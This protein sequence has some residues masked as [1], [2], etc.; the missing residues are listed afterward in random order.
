MRTSLKSLFSLVTRLYDKLLSVIV[1]LGASLIV[2]MMLSIGA[3][4][5]FRRTI[6]DFAWALEISEYILI[7]STLFG[8]GWLLKTGGHVR[9]DALANLL[10]GRTRRVYN[11]IIFSL[12]SLVC[13]SFIL[14]GGHASYE[15]YRSG[16]IEEKVYLQFPKWILLS[17]FP[18]GGVFMTIEAIKL[19]VGSFSKKHSKW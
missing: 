5:I 11:C 15:A 1:A 3:S 12:V 17:L 8:A 9:V 10:H 18:L 13:I 14:V 2:F 19:A 16:I 7:V 6:V 4:V